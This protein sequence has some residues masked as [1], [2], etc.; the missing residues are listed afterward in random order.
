MS[1]LL[2]RLRKYKKKDDRGIMA[3]LRCILVESK[4]HRA[5]PALHRLGVEI[6]DDLSAYI[7][8]LFSLHPEETT[9]G[10]FGVTCKIIEERRGDT[11]RDDNKVTATEKRFQHLLT[12]EKGEELY[13][14]VMRLVHMAKSQD[15]PVNYEKL[16]TDLKYWNDHTK[17]EWATSFWA[18]ET[19]ARFEESI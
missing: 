18:Q 7:A 13:G 3:N 8:G 9:S 11:R 6:N 19:Q 12:A 14:R 1:R 5:W 2:F 4:K 15:I 16:M 17:I 10:N